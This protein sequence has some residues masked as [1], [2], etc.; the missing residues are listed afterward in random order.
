MNKIDW[1]NI[2]KINL[3]NAGIKHDIIKLILVRKILN[4]Y[5]RKHWLRIY[6][7]YELENRLKPDIYVEDIKNKSVIIYEI[8]KEY[9]PEWIKEKS[10]QYKEY[11]NY[12]E[13]HFNYSVDFIP[14]D[15]NVFTD[16]INEIEE[17]LEEYLF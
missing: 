1:K 17:K 13:K 14:L 12:Q 8:Q 11:E 2:Y 6:T 10:K 16:D 3:S 7:E 9:T 15:L 4:K 5:S